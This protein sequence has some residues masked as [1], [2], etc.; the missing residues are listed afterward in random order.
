MLK[1]K[2]ITFTK[3]F[4]SKVNVDKA[5]EMLNAGYSY[6]KIAKYF[7][8]DKSSIMAFHRRKK[9]EGIKFKKNRVF[10]LTIS[11]TDKPIFYPPPTEKINEGKSYGE[12]LEGYIKKR[13]KLQARLMR[14]AKKTI[15]KVI[16]KRIKEGTENDETWN[17]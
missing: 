1:K 3:I 4:N 6:Y 5:I 7:H 10:T 16:K 8:C 9:K 13:D 14:S 2:R 15:D 11:F 12:Y 17:F